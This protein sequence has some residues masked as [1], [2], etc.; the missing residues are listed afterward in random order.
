M[1]RILFLMLLL[2][3]TVFSADQSVSLIF[4]PE[5]EQF[6]QATKDYQ[7]IWASD[8]IRIIQAMEKHSGLKFEESEV[9]VI[10]F[11]GMSNSGFGPRPMK[12]RASYPPDTK[13]ATLIHE[14]GHRLHGR[15]FKK[16]EEDHLYLFLYLY[17][18][19]V[20]LYGKEFADEQVKIESERRGHFDYEGVWKQALS[21]TAEERKQKW[22]EFLKSKE[23]N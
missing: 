11:E 3:T 13:K 7:A 12:M 21:M 18:V 10:V 5:S 16:D 6:A 15:Y 8:G 19:W 22:Q 20:D 4:E 1:K 17:D 23:T 9:R 14:L 2:T